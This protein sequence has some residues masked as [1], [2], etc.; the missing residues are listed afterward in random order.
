M[1]TNHD[2]LYKFLNINLRDKSSFPLDN[3]YTLESGT[4]V[5]SIINL[6]YLTNEFH[7]VPTVDIIER[8]MSLFSHNLFFFNETQ[9][10]MGTPKKE[11]SKNIDLEE[12]RKSVDSE[13]YE[14]N[15]AMQI[16]MSNKLIVVIFKTT[17]QLKVHRL[18]Y[19][20]KLGKEDYVSTVGMNIVKSPRY[21]SVLDLTQP[22]SVL[23]V[24]SIRLFMD[25]NKPL[26]LDDSLYNV[27]NKYYE[28]KSND[29]FSEDFLLQQCI[30]VKKAIYK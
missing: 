9:F 17:K 5:F 29:T 4:L 15:G 24:D 16:H 1:K 26:K 6:S 8:Y 2:F 20:N 7:I 10:E 30:K 21:I 28:N 14:A 23:K 22:S 13:N 18:D 3:E 25:P 27:V 12:A 11:E 19:K